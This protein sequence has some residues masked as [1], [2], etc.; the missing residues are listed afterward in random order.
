[1][2][3]LL[4]VYLFHFPLYTVRMRPKAQVVARRLDVQQAGFDSCP[5]TPR[6]P[7][8]GVS[9]EEEDT[10]SGPRQNCINAVFITEKEI[11]QTGQRFHNIFRSIKYN[12]C[13][14]VRYL[15]ICKMK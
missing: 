8:L 15:F 4:I 5:G 10:E 14:I 12:Q 2:C 7:L 9:C 6:T 13:S 3:G 1:V 11:K